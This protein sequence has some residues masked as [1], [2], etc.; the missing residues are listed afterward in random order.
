MRI[1]YKLPDTLKEL[2]I[3]KNKLATEGKFRVAT[4]HELERGKAKSISFETLERILDAANKITFS[5]GKRKVILNDIIEYIPDPDI[6][7]ENN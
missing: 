5:E 1:K 7:K 6:E 4:L 3:T 2:D